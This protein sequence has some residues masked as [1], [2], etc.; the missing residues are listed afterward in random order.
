M[1]CAYS[2][3]GQEFEAKTHNQRYCSDECCRLAT[4]ARLMEQYYEKKARLKGHIRVC[5]TPDCGTVLSRYN[6]GKVCGKCEA[7]NAQSERVELLFN[8]VGI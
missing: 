6:E 4:N 7:A 1:N 2:E 8:L 5:I 3:C